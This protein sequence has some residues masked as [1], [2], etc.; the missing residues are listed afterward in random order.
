MDDMKEQLDRK[1]QQSSLMA[2]SDMRTIQT[3]VA[4]KNKVSVYV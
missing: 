4:E 1:S 2:D 3:E